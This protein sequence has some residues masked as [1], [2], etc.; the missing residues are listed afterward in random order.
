MFREGAEKVPFKQILKGGEGGQRVPLAL[1]LGRGG[2]TIPASLD[3]YKFL[4]VQECQM[5]HFSDWF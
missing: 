5:H 1:S 3:I 2:E 4:G